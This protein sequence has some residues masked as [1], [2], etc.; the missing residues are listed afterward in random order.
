MKIKLL[1]PLNLNGKSY[2][3]GEEVQLPPIDA[4]ALLKAKLAVAVY[5]RA[6]HVPEMEIRDA[7]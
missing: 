7:H 5:E 3:S 2:R 1:Q 4:K 6:V